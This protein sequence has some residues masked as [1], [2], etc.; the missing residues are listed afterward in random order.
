MSRRRGFIGGLVIFIFLISCQ[1]FAQ[2]STN[3]KRTYPSIT[4][5][6]INP[7]PPKIDGN[8]NDP[9]WTNPEL[10]VHKEFTQRGPEDGAAPTES[11]YVA[12]A[13]DH[14][15]V[16]CAFWCF[17]SEPEQIDQQL[18]RRDRHSESDYV[19][20]R[21]DPYHDGQTGQQFYLTAAGVQL[22]GRIYNDGWTDSSWDVVWHGSAKM[23]PWGWS[24]EYEIP[25]HC[26]R[27]EEKDNHTW[28]VQFARWV[29]RKAEALWWSYAPRSESGMVSH[30]G[31]LTG[32]T[33]IKPARHLEVLPYAVSDVVVSDKTEG[34][35]D[36]RDWREN[37]GVDVKYGITTNLTLDA[38]INPDFGQVELDQPVLN[39]SA[40]ET[41]FS[42]R[43][44]FFIEGSDLFNT[45]F[46]LF[47]SRRIGR[48]PRGSVND[49]AYDYS[50]NRPRATS[51][52]GAAKL[53]GKIG[54]KTSVAVLNAVTEEESETYR[55]T[56]GL[57]RSQ[58]IE[59]LANYSVFR[60]KQDVLS[61]SFVGIMG[62]LAAQGTKHPAATGGVDWRLLTSNGVWALRGQAIAGRVD[63]EH[64][65]FGIDA[66]LDKRSGKHFRGALGFTNKDPHLDIND[67]GFTNRNDFRQVWLWTQYRTQEPW[68][69]IRES[70]NNFN[71]NSAWNYNGDNISRWVNLNTYMEFTNNWSLG[72]GVGMQSEP[73]SDVETRG[74]G[75]WEWNEYPTFSW[76]LSLNT[77]R[78]KMLSYNINPGSGTDRGGTWWA[79][80]VGVE[81]RPKSNMEF[82]VGANYHRTFNGTRWVDNIDVDGT[83][84][85][86]FADLDKDQ[87][88]LHATAG[89]MVRPNLHVQ[90]SGQ[91]LISTLDY[92]DYKLYRGGKDYAPALDHGDYDGTFS[93]LNS[94]LI[95]RW[96]YVPGSTLYF[97]W[98]RSRPEWDNQVNQLHLKDE[99][100]RFFSR[101]AE[102]VWLVKVSYWWNM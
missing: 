100:D 37:V 21:L 7:H 64:T 85:S 32:L 1:A 41:R 68:W 6:R 8:V 36:G 48:Q 13:Y 31:D 38:T 82:E 34:N 42:E 78:R 3:T 75:L 26:L 53:T 84:E 17:D 33:G 97:V 66:T 69:I 76:W 22:D 43:R 98:T 30:F 20:F 40:F 52:L 72:G 91:G 89:M 99:L 45:D 96:E 24:A 56:G 95:M 54:G 23:Q 50:L 59:P 10:E 86:L 27:F 94:M 44:P 12:V 74:N 67:L 93:A 71:A 70:Y 15:A 49:E 55:T 4:A 80:Y 58:V 65:G 25:Y 11:T 5:L 101:G 28:G 19:V 16:Y 88:F 18:V 9:I 46:S 39:L 73:Y 83:T 60:V 90:I 102:N 87:V 14:E 79:N 92:Q 81:F 77:D 29:N 35:P 47:Y 63:D 61:N 62:T 2:D 51:I 57:Q